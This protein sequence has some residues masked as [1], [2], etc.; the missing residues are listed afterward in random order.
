MSRIIYRKLHDLSAKRSCISEL[1]KTEMHDPGQ[2]LAVTGFSGK[3]SENAAEPMH[4]LGSCNTP[5]FILGPKAAELLGCVPSTI[6]RQ[7]KSGKFQGAKK[8]P[9]DGV[10]VWQIPIASLPPSAQMMMLAEVKAALVEKAVSRNLPA[11]AQASLSLDISEY[12]ALWDA[13]E[14]SGASTKRKAELALTALHTFH[15]LVDTG[16]H[17]EEATKAVASKH[18]VSKATLWRYRT[19]TEGHGRGYW[20]PLLS[21]KYKGGRPLAEFTDAAYEWI[22][23][24]VLTTSKQ[25]FTAVIDEARR[26]AKTAAWII[27]SNDAVISRLKKEPAWLVHAGR[28]GFESLERRFPTVERDYHNLGLHQCWDS[29]GRRADVM[30]VWPDGSIARP[31]IIAWREVRTR[32]V[33]GVRGCLNPTA[34]MVIAAYGMA[35]QRTGVAPKHSKLDNGREYAAK[36]FTGGQPTRYRF[37][38][39]PG[40][41]PGIMTLTG[42]KAEWSK[43]YKG[44]DKPIESFWNLIADYVDKTFEGAYCGKDSASKPEGYDPKK[45]A[46]PIAEYAARLESLLHWYNTE[47]PHTGNGMNGCTPLAKY[48]ELWEQAK[49]SFDPVD[50]AHIRLCKMGMKQI[51]MG[52]AEDSLTLTVPGFGKLRFHNH[53]L[54]SS[55]NSDVRSRQLNV[56]YDPDFPIAVEVW[57]GEARLGEAQV[58]GTVDFMGAKEAAAAHEQAKNAALKPKKAAL[59]A[60]K[61]AGEAPLLLPAPAGLGELPRVR[62][63]APRVIQQPVEPESSLEPTDKPGEWIDTETGKIYQRQEHV[64]EWEKNEQGSDAEDEEIERLR[65]VQEEKN[66]PAWLRGNA[67]TPAECDE[68]Q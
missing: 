32:L 65:K 25:P 24:R 54:F 66:L 37:K 57:D 10:E 31:F 36:S 42:T 18:G 49:H 45:H 51:K 20:L 13:Y 53:D 6:T 33:L 4:D 39:M 38:I 46:I 23:S 8:V 12:R 22:K 2:S 17:I 56:Y 16:F 11:L 55:F 30:C 44:R 64:M 26:L 5:E 9:V 52:K 19:R 35:L 58:I 60:A 40:E 62:I 67:T 34:E 1:P 59:K 7:C 14:R 28:E 29:D 50:P 61:N 63:D 3:T 47:R 68:S 15:D 41:Q 27:P 48:Q 21:P 43:P